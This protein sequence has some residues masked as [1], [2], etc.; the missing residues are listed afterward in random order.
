MKQVV[1][2]SK[3]FPVPVDEHGVPTVLPADVAFAI[4]RSWVKTGMKPGAAAVVEVSQKAA[5]LLNF[6]ET[7]LSVFDGSSAAVQAWVQAQGLRQQI[8]S[9]VTR[10][11]LEDT[12]GV[13]PSFGPAPVLP[14]PGTGAAPD[15]WEVHGVAPTESLGHAASERGQLAVNDGCPDDDLELLPPLDSSL[16][17]ASVPAKAYASSHDASAAST[18]GSYRNTR[19]CG[20]MDAEHPAVSDGGARVDVDPEMDMDLPVENAESASGLPQAK[21]PRL[22]TD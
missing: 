2:D 12:G 22:S 10:M 5:S 17:N 14:E 4:S 19:A 1:H 16:A 15:E 18:A 20:S 13:Y 8:F 9:D 7:R 21:R 11:W 3:T 6:R